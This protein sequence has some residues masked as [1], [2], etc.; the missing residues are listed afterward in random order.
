MTAL[1]ITHL[2]TKEGHS[3]PL[4]ENIDKIFVLLL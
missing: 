2:L 4:H 3:G 1:Q